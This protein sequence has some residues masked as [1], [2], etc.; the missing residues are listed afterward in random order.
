VLADAK[1][2]STAARPSTW[3]TKLAVVLLLG[4]GGYTA[5]KARKDGLLAVNRDVVGV[6]PAEIHD[7]INV[8]HFTTRDMES[9]YMKTM[10]RYPRGEVALD[11]FAHLIGDQVAIVMERR[12][13]QRYNR[14]RD[15]E[16]QQY[17][18]DLAEVRLERDIARAKLRAQAGDDGAAATIATLQEQLSARVKANDAA[19]H[20]RE[21]DHTADEAEAHADGHPDNAYNPLDAWIFFRTCTPK[22]NGR[23]APYLSPHLPG[24]KSFDPSLLESRPRQLMDVRDLMVGMSTV[25]FDHVDLASR[26][27]ERKGGKNVPDTL[28]AL[29][30]RWSARDIEV[31]TRRPESRLHFAFRVAD[32]DRDGRI[33]FGELE[34]LLDRLMRTGHFRAESLVRVKLPDRELPEG[35]GLPAPPVRAIAPW[36][37]PCP[38]P[39]PVQFESRTPAE[40]ARDYWALIQ[41]K[42]REEALEALK[43]Q[44]EARKAA[45]SAAPAAPVASSARAPSAPAV[46]DLNPTYSPTLSTLSWSELEACSRHF[47]RTGD[48]AVLWYMNDVSPT[49]SQLGSTAKWRAKWSA[50]FQ[51]RWRRVPLPIDE[52]DIDKSLLIAFATP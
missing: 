48:S 50:R 6:A 24:P 14:Q 16:E 31:F 18:D 49:G 47:A 17:A 39:F 35:A 26:F 1:A 13:Q 42:R 27:A 10:R 25:L 19:Q 11:D 43:Q 8:F 32:E 30:A 37:R 36:K 52:A 4:L 22:R 34:R 33:S 44:I 41:T 38:R 9:L 28:D 15:R 45:G 7:L 20:L 40:V 3:R 12:R 51:R 29:Q 23:I 46:L 21:R 5:W 2:S